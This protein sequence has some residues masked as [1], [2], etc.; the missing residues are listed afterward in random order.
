[1]PE[2]YPSFQDEL[3]S[4]TF[5]FI[6]VIALFVLLLAPTFIGQ[7][8]IVAQGY[9]E[10]A[11]FMNPFMMMAG[12]TLVYYGVI[13]F[14]H[15]RLINYIDELIYIKILI[16]AAVGF[17]LIAD[18]YMAYTFQQVFENNQERIIRRDIVW[19][20]VDFIDLP[21]DV[22][23]PN[24]RAAF[25]GVLS[26]MRFCVVA[27]ILYKLVTEQKEPTEEDAKQALSLKARTKEKTVDELKANVHPS[28][29]KMYNK[30]KQDDE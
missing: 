28:V 26:V 30:E 29:L 8:F 23:Y 20:D 6:Q 12:V 14:F 11:H 19:S 25:L 16:V 2:Q 4:Y 22:V 17:W 15:K 24:F 27:L 10:L 7:R 3:K 1:M 13:A 18:G 5:G 9:T 21:A